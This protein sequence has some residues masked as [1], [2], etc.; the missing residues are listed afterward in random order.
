MA[1]LLTM[2]LHPAAPVELADQRWRGLAIALLGGLGIWTVHFLAMLGFRPDYP[3]SYD[4]AITTASMAI[5]MLLVGTPLALVPTTRSNPA[6]FAGGAVAGAGVAIMHFVG[7]SALRGCGVRHS[8]TAQTIILLIGAVLMGSAVALS[9]RAS[10]RLLG[11]A[12]MVACTLLV[13]TLA[14]RVMTVE[15]TYD[16]YPTGMASDLFGLIVTAAAAALLLAGIAIRFSIVRLG[17]RHRYS[18]RL[19]TALAHMSNG[20]LAIEPDGTVS[21][22]NE[23]FFRLLGLPP[24]RVPKGIDWKTFIRRNCMVM[25]WSEARIADLLDLHEVWFARDTRTQVEME[26]G[27][28]RTISVACDPLP[29]GGVVLTFDDLTTVLAQAAERERLAAKADQSER[30]FERLVR[31]I[32]DYA[33]CLIN[34]DGT[35]ANWNVGAERLKGYRAEEIVG[36]HFGRFYGAADRWAGVPN[37]NLA[38]ALREGR[39]EDEAPRFRKDGTSFLANVVIDPIF[40]DDGSLLGFA[41]IT[42]DR[43]EYVRNAQSIDYMARHDALTR[44][45]NRKHFLDQLDTTLSAMR[46]RGSGEPAERLAVISIDLDGFKGINDAYGHSTADALLQALGARMASRLF[47][48]EL[49]ARL[50]SDEFI[51]FKRY[52][53]AAELDGF[54]ERLR[55]ATS[56][57]VTL[58]GCRLIP[59]ASM[60]VARF[61]DDAAT[62]DALMTEADLAMNRA[63]GS[64]DAKICFFEAGL[65][66]AARQ[67]RMLIADMWAAIEAG[68]Q[69]HIH[70]QSQHF[71][72]SK[73]VSG[74]EALLRWSHPVHGAISPAVFIPL[75]E[76]SGAIM[77]LGEWVLEQ[78]CRDA[79]AFDL[80]RIAVNLSPLQLNDPALPERVLAVLIRTGLSPT[81][82]ELEITESA[83][84]DDRARALDVL[85]RIKAMGVAIAMDD[86]GTGYSS[87]ETLRLFPF[88]RLK[89][90]RSFTRG[91]DDDA[92]AQAF[93][94]AIM[95]LANSLD[96]TVI[97]EGIE[98]ASQVAF[99]DA[100]GCHELQ[101]FLFG[102]PAP[103]DTIVLPPA[104]ASAA[105]AIMPDE[106]LR[107]G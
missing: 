36:E 83:L 37:R 34:P 58:P 103:I 18:M 30:V 28:G 67:Q 42:R 92:Q 45:S 48:G 68:D 87:L 46:E 91:L 106:A 94:Q 50:G 93:V 26:I 43:T 14:M 3:I 51:A 16:T 39:F 89:L 12:L 65:D 22:A 25:G 35:V 2:L 99:L 1:W 10:F 23:Q 53:G 44:L 54:L 82:L 102:R 47:E 101:G 85:R 104:M 84:I 29:N 66:T 15:P 64:R 59:Q 79:A 72:G 63:K 52:D 33:I 77:R 80:P 75:A 7:M 21:I 24:A 95:S 96:V 70:Y 71:T 69:F 61:P 86:F 100:A 78:A 6:R 19:S 9:H 31:G 27:E 97:A 88:D 4:P 105:I 62:R 76:S 60:G 74:Y 11:C 49:I 55:H 32:S 20:L 13:H 56:E 8:D 81:R 5:S 98:L 17:E 41:K 107:H 38:T 57:P 40:L 73:A 90:D